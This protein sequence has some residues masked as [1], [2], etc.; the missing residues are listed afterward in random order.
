[1]LPDRSK[2]YAG[3]DGEIPRLGLA[4]NWQLFLIALLVVAL[5]VMIFPRRSLVEKIYEQP[6]MDELTL[7]YIQNIYRSDKSDADVAILLARAQQNALG[8]E[9]QEELLL[10]L[11]QS[12]DERQ[13]NEARQLLVG[14]YQRALERPVSE[15]RRQDIRS[16][17]GALVQAA[18]SD[19]VPPE[20]ARI[21]VTA[22]FALDL[23]KLGLSFLERTEKGE[24][25]AALERFARVALSVGE[26]AMAAQYYLH[27]SSHSQ[28][29]AQT[30]RLFQL[31]IDT[32]LADSLYAPALEAADKFMET[33][34]LANDPET[35]RYMVRIARSAGKPELAAQYARALVYQSSGGKAVRTP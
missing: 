35:L 20:L 29:L 16:R 1:M 32:Y 23:P 11:T 19:T 6:V 21:L 5:L 8:V 18:S 13:R 22:A 27:A 15:A 26:Y 28:D 17:F 14:V 31:G 33:D 7:S 4:S 34:R 25:I 3:I 30:R 10:K 2:R 9:A 12:G 24:S